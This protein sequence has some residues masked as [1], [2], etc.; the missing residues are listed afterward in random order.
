VWLLEHDVPSSI[1]YV[2]VVEGELKFP[3]IVR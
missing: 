1:D 3:P 2:L